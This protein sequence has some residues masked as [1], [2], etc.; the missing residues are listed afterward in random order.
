MR[1]RS[2]HDQPVGFAQR[3]QAMGDGDRRAALDQVVERQLNLAL[4]LGID[5]DGG[6]V[7]DQ[8]PRIDQQRPGDRNALPLA[9]GERLAA[10][11][12]QRVVTQGQ[13]QDELVGPRGSARRR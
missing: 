1:P 8:D 2:K 10:L 11:A 12:D 4:G 6:L 5:R 13:P 3:A 9:A 7:E